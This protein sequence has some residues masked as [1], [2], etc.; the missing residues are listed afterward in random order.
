LLRR[1][2][3][4]LCPDLLVYLLP[5][6]LRHDLRKGWIV[7]IASEYLL[8]LVHAVDELAFQGLVED[9]LEV[10]QFQPIY[11]IA[12]GMD[13]DRAGMFYGNVWKKVIIDRPELWIGIR[14]D[15]TFP[16]RGISLGGK[17]GSVLV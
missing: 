3:F 1:L 4:S 10:L 13:E 8:V 2:L 15:P 14:S 16:Q 9:V 11:E 17:T 5:Q 6:K 7:H 12:C